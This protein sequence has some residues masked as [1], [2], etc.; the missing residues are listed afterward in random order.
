MTE[1]ISEQRRARRRRALRNRVIVGVV[2][3]AAVA[4]LVV[5]NVNDRREQQR[6]IAEL[7]AGSCVFDR[8]S[9]GGSEHIAS[10]VY[11]VDPPSGGDHTARAAGAGRYSEANA[12]G[13]GELVHAME[14]GYVILWHRP[15]ITDAQQET[16]DD[17][18]AT[19]DRDVLVVARSSLETPVAATAW[20]RRLLCRDVEGEVLN[21][22]VGEY[23]NKGPEKVPH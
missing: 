2:V 10:P 21:R 8:R 12:P 15:D 13:Q 3:A 23:R 18:A 17:I 5:K 20:H 6:L 4:V 11:R 16:V 22:F 9:D 1:R 19:F 7:T 14:H